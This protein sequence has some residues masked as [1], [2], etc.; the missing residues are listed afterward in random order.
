MSKRANN[1]SL[2]LLHNS[3]EVS[4]PYFGNV[5]FCKS[6]LQQA[7]GDID[8]I[9]ISIAPFYSAA[10]VKIRTDADM[11]D[12]RH[13]NHVEQ[14]I[15]KVG[16]IGTCRQRRCGTSLPGR[17]VPEPGCQERQPQ[18]LYEPPAAHD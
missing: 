11:V 9:V 2:Y 8:E 3:Q 6:M 18:R 15:H 16:K 12:A 17:R 1:L 4:T 5:C 10:T 7:D 14:M 13:F